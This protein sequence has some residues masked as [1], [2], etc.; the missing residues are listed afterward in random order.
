MRRLKYRS[1][2]ESELSAVRSGC[3]TFDEFAR[4]TGKEWDALAKHVH[5]H[6]ITP[7]AVSQEDARQEMLFAAWNAINKWEERDNGMG[8]KSFVIWVAITV[9]TKWLHVQRNALRRD[10][11][12]PGRF[13]L[14]I[15]RITSLRARKIDLP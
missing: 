3:K 8:L 5:S 2:M 10:S 4:S 12:A 7:Y 11:H 13:D 9:T 14:L 6:W 15:L 1:L